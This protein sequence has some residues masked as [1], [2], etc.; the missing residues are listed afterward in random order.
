MKLV[1]KSIDH[2]GHRGNRR[3]ITKVI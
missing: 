2:R 3:G 1:G